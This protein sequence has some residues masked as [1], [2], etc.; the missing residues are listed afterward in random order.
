MTTTADDQTTP[1]VEDLISDLISLNVG[2]WQRVSE[3]ALAAWN[4]AAQG[5]YE[6]KH[7]LRDATHF[8]AGMVKDASRAFVMVR[9][10]MVATSGQNDNPVSDE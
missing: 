1:L 4:Q 10:F 8:W 5:E 7:L 6:P 2:S 3:Q 9:D